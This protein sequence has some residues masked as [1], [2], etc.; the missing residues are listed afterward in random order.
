M[1]ETFPTIEEVNQ[2]IARL[3]SGLPL[4]E[5][6]ELSDGKEL[7]YKT[8]EVAPDGPAV[9]GKVTK[10]K[11]IH[12]P[13]S[14][15]E[16]I[17]NLEYMN[18]DRLGCVNGVLFAKPTMPGGEI[19]YLHAAPD[20]FSFIGVLN[21]TYPD[22]KTGGSFMS[23]LEAYSHVKHAARKYRNIELAP[24]QPPMEG[25]YYNYPPLPEPDHEAFNYV[26]DQF[27]PKTEYDRA[28][29]VAM[30][31]TAFWGGTLRM[32][33]IFT[34]SAEQ[35]QGK[36]KSTVAY[37][38]AH[39]LGQVAIESKT[40]EDSIA[41]KKRLLSEEGMK[42][43]VILYD[44]EVGDNQ[45][46]SSSELAAMVTSPNISGHK[47]FAGEG[48]RPNN[49]LWI[50]TLN[51]VAFDRDLAVRSIPIELS[52]P[53]Y[54]PFW[55]SNL[56]RYIDEHRLGIWAAM[57]D[58]LKNGKRCEITPTRWGDWEYQV[59]GL[60]AKWCDDVDGLQKLIKER[61]HG[62]DDETDEIEDIKDACV[63]VIKHNGCDPKHD[64]CF[65]PTSMI[66]KMYRHETGSTRALKS[67]VT[68]RIRQMTKSGKLK[69][70]VYDRKCNMRGF[71]WIG[72]LAFGDNFHIMKNGD[73]NEEPI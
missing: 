26:I 12:I 51:T 34:V 33:P 15:N 19:R 67:T 68:K 66:V 61:Q 45:R 24:H 31:L 36:G 8:I 53:E 62:A 13:L 16:T 22:W 56:N 27:N 10:P 6:K 64:Q 40:S 30:Y 41:L 18:H 32:R 11:Q 54:S 59:L 14:F 55:E 4:I 71:M 52:E 1:R 58:I 49:F 39:I 44:N 17:K 23:K 29:I 60:A 42:S 25:L 46:V 5:E 2:Q 21:H 47:M 37:I 48:T 38:L 28:L 3:Q 57:L 70:L 20:Y 72:G 65:F 73:G 69:E 63:R 50:I 35:G 9:K 43:R 7:N